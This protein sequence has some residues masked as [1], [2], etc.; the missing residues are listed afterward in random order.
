MIFNGG[1][2]LKC[3]R[4]HDFAQSLYFPIRLEYTVVHLEFSQRTNTER[5]VKMAN[6]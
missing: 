3:G 1:S 6:G 2:V 5:F 4:I